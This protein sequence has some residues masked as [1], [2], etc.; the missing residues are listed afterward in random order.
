MGFP[1]PFFLPLLCACI[2]KLSLLSCVCV[3]V[4]LF[5]RFILI[6]LLSPFLW[7]LVVLIY[8]CLVGLHVS[9]LKSLYLHFLAA[10]ELKWRTPCFRCKGARSDKKAAS[11]ISTSISR[12]SFWLLS[13]RYWRPWMATPR[14]FVW[15][16]AGNGVIYSRQKK[17]KKSLIL[18]NTD[19]ILT[20][21]C[22]LC[23]IFS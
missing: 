8:N 20:Y 9:I 5:S 13:H 7:K 4:L 23:L 18:S 1:C 10:F 17:K 14:K 16:W 15:T 22:V 2:W 19:L 3:L 12:Y 21:T 11:E 6:I